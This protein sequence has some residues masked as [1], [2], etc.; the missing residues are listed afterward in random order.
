MAE[1]LRPVNCAVRENI[2][3]EL[4]FVSAHPGIFQDG[5]CLVPLAG[6]KI[7]GP[8]KMVIRR[9]LGNEIVLHCENTDCPFNR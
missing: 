5:I 2:K 6:G 3:P 7:A 8:A 1:K 9:G 4:S